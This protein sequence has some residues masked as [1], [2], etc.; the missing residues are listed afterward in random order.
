[1]VAEL[2]GSGTLAAMMLLV[3]TTMA[4]L[5][6]CAARALWTLWTQ[7]EQ[8]KTVQGINDLP[9][10]TIAPQRGRKYH[11]TT[12]PHTRANSDSKDSARAV[13]I[14]RRSTCTRKPWSGTRVAALTAVVMTLLCGTILGS[15]A[16]FCGMMMIPGIGEQQL[17]EYYQE[18]QYKEQPTSSSQQRS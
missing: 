5:A 3:G 2:P 11:R 16:T 8:T 17:G 6:L 15:L 12:C 4:A 1:M 7:E 18:Q 10:L 14:S 9:E 13:F